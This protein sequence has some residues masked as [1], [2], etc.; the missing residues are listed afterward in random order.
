MANGLTYTRRLTTVEATK[1]LA[2]TLAQY[3]HP[4]DVVI[5][6]G[7]LG[8]GKTQFVQ[9]VA[10]AL[11]IQDQVISPTFNIL[12]S[13]TTGRLPLY[14]FDLYRLDDP[15]QLEDIG[16]FETLEG[17]GVSFIEWGNKFPDVMPYGYLHIDIQVEGED[18][19]LIAHSV[20]ERS[21]QMLFV[22]A[23]DSRTRL[24]K[25]TLY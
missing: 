7:G 11:G 6:T 16:Y 20:G 8:A 17:D 23:Q 9:G 4:G 1:Q 12:L 10:E 19:V 15:H 18:R 22:W 25:T 14:H 24:S 21:R 5:L 13:Y 2:A 3:L